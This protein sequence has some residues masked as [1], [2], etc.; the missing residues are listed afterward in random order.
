[1]KN[2]Y[3]TSLFLVVALCFSIKTSAT[4]KFVTFHKEAAS[5][6]LFSENKTAS[7]M[8]DDQDYKGVLRAAGDLRKDIAKVTGTLPD[9]GKGQY[10]IIIGTAG[11]STVIDQLIKSNKIEANDI[12]GKNEKYIIKTIDNPIEGVGQ[13]LVIAG[14]DKRGTIYGIYELSAQIGV[15]PWYY[16][17]D[18]PV[19][20]Q[21]EVFIKPGTY[22]DGEPAVQYRGIFLNDEA[23]ALSGWASAT[24]GGFNHKFYEKVFELILRLKGNFLW[25][26]MWGSAFY[27]DDPLNGELADEYGIVISTSHHEPLGRAHAEWNRYGKG[28]WNYNKNAKTLQEFWKGGMERMKN[29]ETIVTVGMRGDG[30]EPMSEESDVA[31]LQKIVKDQRGIIAQVTNKKV[32]ETPQV[33]ALYKEVQDYYDKGMR[34]PDDITLL[35]CDDNW[36]NVR[37]LPDL[38]TK[39]HKGG[40]GMYYHFDYV[41]GP[42]N[43]KWINVSQVQRIWEQMNLTYQYGV[44]KIWI[45][46]VGDLKPMEYPISFFL[47][48]AWNPNQF[49]AENLLDHTEQWCAQQFGEKYAKE[50]ARLINLYTKYNRRV[51][52]EL[53]NENTYSLENYDEFETV[54]NDYRNLVV[55]AMRL[56]YLIPDNYKDAFDQL[57][58]FP[59]NACSNLYEMY[60]AV[61]KNREYAAK[62]DM[63]ANEWADKAKECFERDSLLTVHYNK[64][65]AGGKWPHMMDQVRIGYTS[66]Q[67]PD[68]SI[69]PKVE[70]LMQTMIYKEKVFA[71][72]DSYVSIESENFTR[73][74]SSSNISWTVIPHLGKTLSGITTMPVTLSPE[75]EDTYLE[76]DVELNTT[77]EAK[78]I[79]LVSPTLN[80]NSNKGLRYAVSIDGGKEQIVNINGHYRG[81]LGEWQANSIIETSTTH[82][83]DNVGRH[84]IRFRPL[85]QGIVLQKVMLD[86]GGLKPSY[87]GAPQSK[88]AN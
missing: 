34:V 13:A 46:N 75:N 49:N 40:Y 11:K 70:Y 52:P 86:M 82:P 85:D 21:K 67:Q 58:L 32:E 12:L 41:G 20:K 73:Q 74:N 16:W 71:E 9:T 83:I 78:L 44:N 87:L 63:I 10:T 66:W 80:F 4:D 1:M 60:Y 36:G 61:A 88:L 31:L 79:V 5:F 47:D 26:A 53:L 38:N 77:G 76:Y 55:D 42:R 33:W 84:T 64:D 25:P 30:D 72:S 27:D 59:I 57:V 7:V 45:V 48:M 62:G 24:F 51:T 22:T 28:A 43:Y 15:S 56:Y 17:A 65:I 54:V 39:P 35:L 23:P 6:C 37:K 69:M 81:E 19:E 18:V 68:K 29:Y 50:S 2:R 14:S 8:V 3:L